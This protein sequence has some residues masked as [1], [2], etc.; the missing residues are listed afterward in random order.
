MKL[1]I[2]ALLAGIGIIVLFAVL[3]AK[4][5]ST[6]PASDSAKTQSDLGFSAGAMGESRHLP[7]LDA[8]S[9]KATLKNLIASE[10][11]P[12]SQKH[13]NEK[14]KSERNLLT[15]G[16]FKSFVHRCF[17]GEDCELD[18]DPRKFYRELMANDQRQDADL[19]ISYLRSRL[20]DPE[21]RA[22]YKEP[23]LEMIHDFY[24]REEI[25]FQ[26]AAY[27]NYLNELE[28]SLDLYLDL[29]KKS[30]TD[31][32]LRSA[33]KL[34]I[35]NTFYDLGR[36]KEALPYYEA[37]LRGYLNGQDRVVVPSQN[38]MIRFIEDRI[39]QIR[40]QPSP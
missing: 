6:L 15:A 14:V 9:E 28:K 39:E 26:A 3:R 31:P 40:K 4:D 35:A 5:V 32:S 22:R 21:D 7:G 13:K 37:A 38:E 16:N 1:I 2:S 20:K 8:Q 30:T 19:L 33:P 36:S 23:L 17:Q 18:E 10:T 12:E 27:Y 29:E 24:P 34:N 25:Q 11:T